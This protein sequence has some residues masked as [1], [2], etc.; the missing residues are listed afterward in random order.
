MRQLDNVAVF[1][2]EVSGCFSWSS[3]DVTAVYAVHGENEVGEPRDE[4]TD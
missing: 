1:P 4:A 3:I 2:H